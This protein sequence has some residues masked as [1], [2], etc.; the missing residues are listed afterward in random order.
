MLLDRLHQQ[1]SNCFCI[2]DNELGSHI[3]W[4]SWNGTRHIMFTFLKW[5]IRLLWKQNFVVW[6][7]AEFIDRIKNMSFHKTIYYGDH[8]RLGLIFFQP[9]YT[10]QTNQIHVWAKKRLL[11]IVNVYITKYP[12]T[13]LKLRPEITKRN[14]IER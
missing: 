12:L 8:V 1:F 5:L 14:A 10:F 6:I 7:N 4:K 11:E 13:Q 2:I 9:F 3:I